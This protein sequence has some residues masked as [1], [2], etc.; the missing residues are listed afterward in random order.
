M[1]KKNNIYFDVYVKTLIFYFTIVLF[2]CGLG[3]A[4]F[5]AADHKI[6]G[7]I[8]AALLI[9]PLLAKTIYTIHHLIKYSSVDLINIEEVTLNQSY[10]INKQ[11]SK[12]KF[13]YMGKD[14]YTL[15]IFKNRNSGDYTVD[16]Y[17]DKTLTAAYSKKY[18][19]VFLF[20][21]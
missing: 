3:L 20:K 19:E 4:I 6:I 12:F 21:K 10:E 8:I 13:K 14:Y 15:A 9:I 2:A 17:K 5:L 7:L 18:N 11:L 16:K 1:N